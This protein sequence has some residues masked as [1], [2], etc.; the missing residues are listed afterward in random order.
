MDNDVAVAM[1]HFTDTE[2]FNAISSQKEWVF[3]AEQ[4][5]GDHP[6]GA[7]F[8]TLNVDTINLAQRLR[9]PKSKT[10]HYFSFRDQ[11]DLEPLR[12]GRG[13]FIFFSRTDYRVVKQ[14]QL[15]SR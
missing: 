13:R 6:K 7:Y 2:G 5:P 14:R 15:E 3:V 1:N 8:T 9:I 12:G 4:P 10:E 11:G